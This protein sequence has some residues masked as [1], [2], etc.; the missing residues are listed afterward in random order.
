MCMLLLFID[1]KCTI[2]V[3]KDIMTYLFLRK[4]CWLS[5]FLSHLL[6]EKLL[7]SPKSCYE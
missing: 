7:N 1:T 4:T 3:G 2:Y 5:K 6:L